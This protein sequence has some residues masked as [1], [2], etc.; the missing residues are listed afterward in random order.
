MNHRW[1]FGRNIFS[2]LTFFQASHN[3]LGLVVLDDLFL[4]TM[5]TLLFEVLL[6]PNIFL[7]VKG[8]ANLRSAIIST[9]IDM[10]NFPLKMICNRFH[11]AFIM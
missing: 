7:Q 9:P 10:D 3:K 2:R 6:L 4:A 8:L 1:I 11:M 5:L